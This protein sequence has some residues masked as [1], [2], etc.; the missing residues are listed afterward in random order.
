MLILTTPFSIVRD[1]FITSNNS[2]GPNLG[3]DL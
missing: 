1:R 2:V 3:K